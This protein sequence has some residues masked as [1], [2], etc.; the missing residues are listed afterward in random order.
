MNPIYD[1]IYEAVKLCL[2]LAKS[3]LGYQSET[4]ERII[5]I[6]PDYFID[7]ASTY[8]MDSIS[9]MMRVYDKSNRLYR[10]KEIFIEDFIANII[11]EQERKLLYDFLWSNNQFK[12]KILSL[13]YEDKFPYINN[14]LGFKLE[15][16]KYEARD[17]WQAIA[18]LKDSRLGVGIGIR[19][20]ITAC[21][22]ITFETIHIDLNSLKE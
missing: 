13:N 2:A 6:A 16:L 10:N 11:D 19:E 12:Q 15:L 4:N 3:P 17:R 8:C 9:S 18:Y 7:Y 22:P 20:D 21:D 5:S 14:I 1:K